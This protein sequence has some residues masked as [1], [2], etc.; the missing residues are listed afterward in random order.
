MEA[1]Y[2]NV[3]IAGWIKHGRSRIKTP[4]RMFIT[5]LSFKDGDGFNIKKFSYSH[6]RERAQKFSRATAEKVA[7][8]MAVRYI[9][10]ELNSETGATQKV[11]LTPEEIAAAESL[12]KANAELAAEF[13]SIW[14]RMRGMEA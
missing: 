11:E 2:V 5:G 7:R 14:R 13:A 6:E 12:R 8:F 4:V 10:V 1:K 3:S 9:D